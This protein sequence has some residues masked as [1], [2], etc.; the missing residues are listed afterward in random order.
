VREL[1][2]NLFLRDD[3]GCRA[4]SAAEDGVVAVERRC[5]GSGNQQH[6]DHSSEDYGGR[7]HNVVIGFA[8]KLCVP[9]HLN[10]QLNDKWP[11]Q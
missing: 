8:P 5:A 4:R 3:A 6:Y 7:I 1:L 2:E 11:A 10:N 9:S